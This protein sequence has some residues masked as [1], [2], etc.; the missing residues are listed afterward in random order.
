MDNLPE[1]KYLILSYLILNNM[2]NIISKSI[3]IVYKMR[4]YLEL[5][6]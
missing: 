5:K 3:G 1:K 2:K 6:A 4:R